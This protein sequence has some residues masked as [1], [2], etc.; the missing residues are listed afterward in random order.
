MIDLIN[1]TIA[2]LLR[3]RREPLTPELVAHQICANRK[4]L[5]APDRH[6]GGPGSQASYADYEQL[7]ETAEAVLWIMPGWQDRDA[8]HR[9]RLEGTAERRYQCLRCLG[10][11]LWRPTGPLVQTP[12][13]ICIRCSPPWRGDHETARALHGWREAE[14]RGHYPQPGLHRLLDWL[15]DHP[16]QIPPWG[17]RPVLP[18]WGETV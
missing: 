10:W 9:A 1:T 3:E 14:R 8:W 5:A 11:D 15:K 17:L 12:R 18:A 6:D 13:W 16:G 2:E 7:R 4:P